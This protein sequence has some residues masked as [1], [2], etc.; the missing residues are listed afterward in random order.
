MSAKRASVSFPTKRFAT[1]L[2][3]AQTYK[4][5]DSIDGGEVVEVIRMLTMSLPRPIV[6]VMPY[7]TNS[8]SVRRATYADE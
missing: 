6:K 2:M 7:P 4:R 5:E 1:A 3:A 8:E